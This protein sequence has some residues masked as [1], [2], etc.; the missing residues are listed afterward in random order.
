MV[1]I[2]DDYDPQFDGGN[3]STPKKNLGNKLFIYACSRIISH[4]TGL[5][6]VSPENAEIRRE[7]NGSG[8]YTTEPFPFSGVSLGK[9]IEE[10][11]VVIDDHTVIHM[12]T[13]EDMVR[14]NPNKGFLI[15]SYFSKYDYIKPH[16]ELVREFYKPITSPK[17]EDNSIV[18]MLRD[19][20]IDRSFRIDDQYYIDILEQESFDKLYVSLD[21]V[22]NHLGLLNKLKKYDYELI[23]GGII[24]VFKQITSFNKIVA[25]QGTFSFWASFLSDAETIYWPLT[26]DGPNSGNN[27]KN[28]VYNTYVNLLVDDEIRYK[29]VNLV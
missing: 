19:S 3:F 11:L 20:N 16:K 26:Q 8:V 24:D 7:L 15:K 27:S 22:N 28:A 1:K 23:N 21:H 10:P 12:G 25:C 9:K 18:I 2:Y 5:D 4:L 13:I 6:L 29:K 17:R 14:S